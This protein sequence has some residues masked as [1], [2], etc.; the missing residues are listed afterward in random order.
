VNPGSAPLRKAPGD[1]GRGGRESPGSGGSRRPSRGSSRRRSP[2][3]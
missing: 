3:S 2:S 1:R